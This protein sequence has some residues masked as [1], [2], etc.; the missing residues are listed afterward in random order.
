LVRFTS[1]EAL[2]YLGSTAGVAPLA[3]LAERHQQ[4]RF[5]ALL[6]LANLDESV[7][8][9]KLAE[10]LERPDTELRC[11]AF[12]ALRMLDRTDPRSRDERLG[13]ELLND[14]YW[15][16]QVAPQSPPMAYMSLSKRAEIVLF[17]GDVKLT[18]PVKILAGPEFTITAA[19][20]DKSCTVSRIDSKGSA[21]QSEAPM[22][23]AE[24][25]RTMA[26]LGAQYPDVVEFLRKA[27][28]RKCLNCP[29]RINTLP[30][31]VPIATLEQAGRDPN[32][33][34]NE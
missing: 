21:R 3:E 32:C 30:E 33:L 1:A 13:A 23:L 10:L 5:W 28:E 26:D 9:G 12:K 16:H 18:P 7:T 34:R 19:R 25:L 4:V 17:G 14:G 20:F 31:P 24:V 29:L 11:G 22:Q 27:D 6:A 8:R 15:L 2:T